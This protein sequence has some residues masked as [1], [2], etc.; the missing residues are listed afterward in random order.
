MTSGEWPLEPS[1]EDMRAMGE[2]ALEYLVRF[3][4]GLDEAPAVDMDDVEGTV[5]SFREPLPEEGRSFMDVLGQVDLGARKAVDT[6]GPGFLAYI[7]GGGLYSSAVAALLAFGVNRFMNLAPEAPAF[8]QI[9]ATVVGWF[10]RLFGLPEGAGGSL[11]SGGSIANLSALATAR[12]HRGPG[13][14]YVAE[15]A[16]HSVAKAARLVGFGPEDVRG[17]GV[18][19]ELRLDREALVAAVR[20]DRAGGRRPVCVVATGGTT[21]TGTV[22]PL[23]EVAEVA[24]AEGLWYHVDAAYGGFFV[25]TERG[26]ARLRGIELADSLTVDPHK[27]L[28]LPYGTGC[29]LVRDAELLR[30]AHQGRGAYMQDQ[31]GEEGLATSF[32]EYSPELSRDFRG[33]RVWLPIVLHGTGAFRD[34]LDEK[35]DLA[36]LVYEELAGT[37]GFEVP[38]EPDLSTVA[39]RYVPEDG[40]PEAFNRR[41]LERIN[42][43]GRVYLSS[44]MVG[45]RFMIR[46]SVLSHRTHRDRIEEAL[47]IIRREAWAAGDSNPEP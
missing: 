31:E 42:A 36:R 14:I 2:A 21:D 15:N 46:V 18:T 34:A 20:E 4:E 43:S 6:A 45:D 29:L 11:T 5:R 10:A 33:L 7:P 26:R 25:L 12:H 41:L 3:V 23:G 27:G 32:A 35:L 19:P 1:A 30:E 39:F 17:V 16:H 44:T 22:D 24:R 13:V 28:F 40:D 47:A 9:E 8:A 37:P 38:W